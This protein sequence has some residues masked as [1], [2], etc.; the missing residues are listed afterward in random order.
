MK[1]LEIFWA[2]IGGII[3]LFLKENKPHQI[4]LAVAL[5]FM[6]GLVPKTNLVALALVLTLFL[7][8]CNLGFGILTTA[9]VSLAIPRLDPLADSLGTQ[10]LANTVVVDL[11]TTLFRYPLFAWTALNNTV[12]LGSFAAGM[13]AFLPVFLISYGI[14]CRLQ[15]KKSE[16][17]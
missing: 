5:G 8:R 16:S 11:E 6:L 15:T 3:G 1:M 13:I 7:T 9:L 17:Q 10:L 12:V 14:C 2:I 4:A